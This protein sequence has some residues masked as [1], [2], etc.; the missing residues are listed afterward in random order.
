MNKL[1][2]RAAAALLSGLLVCQ[3]FPRNAGHFCPDR[4]YMSIRDILCG[5][6]AARCPDPHSNHIMAPASFQGFCL[7]YIIA[8][9]KQITFGIFRLF[10]RMFGE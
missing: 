3:N 4:I 5:Q 10:Q 8:G 9:K 6:Q 7:F 2:K 1:M